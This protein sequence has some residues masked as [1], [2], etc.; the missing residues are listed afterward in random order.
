MCRVFS[1]KTF[2]AENNVIIMREWHIDVL[3]FIFTQTHTHPSSVLHIHTRTRFAGALCMHKYIYRVQRKL[4]FSLNNKFNMLFPAW[5]TI[6]IFRMLMLVLLICSATLPLRPVAAFLLNFA[7]C[8][9][10]HTYTQEVRHCIWQQCLQNTHI[11][12]LR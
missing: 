1:A 7:W 10:L 3:V 9:A 4:A 11:F 12:K 5:N 6:H 8:T 2:V